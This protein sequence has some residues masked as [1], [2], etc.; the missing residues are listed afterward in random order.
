MSERKIIHVDMDAFYA[1]VEK[2]DNPDLKDRPVIVGGLGNRGVV[3]TASYQARKY[4]VHSAQPMAKA[5]RLCPQAVFLSPRFDRYKEV[6]NQIREIFHQYTP[7]V[8]PISTD[9]AFLDVTGSP[10]SAVKIATEIKEKIKNTTHLTC[11]VGIGPNKFIAKLGSDLEK[12]DGFVHLKKEE[13]DELLKDLEVAKIWGVGEVTEKRLR[14]MGVRTIDDLRKISLKKLKGMFGKQ[15]QS[16]FQLARGIDERPVEPARE[17][18]SLSREVTF[19]KD[20]YKQEKIKARLYQLSQSVARRL[21]KNE[22]KGRTVSIKVRFPDFSCFTR[23][24]T[25]DH[26]TDSTDT[27]YSHAL[28]LFERKVELK[29]RGV[30]LLGVGASNLSKNQDEPNKGQLTLFDRRVLGNRKLDKIIDEIRNKFGDDI[31]KRGV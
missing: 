4:G 27:I 21:R 28:D 9:E 18:K 23:Q 11:S 3:A 22:V 26:P 19:E 1:S 10:Q 8:E 17:P 6:S 15:G 20:I 12:P 30:R 14:D 16:L 7:L 29:N 25:F 5:R 2:L 31:I 13:V 24:I